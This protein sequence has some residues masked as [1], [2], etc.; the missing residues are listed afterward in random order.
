MLKHVAAA[1]VGPRSIERG[2]L[3]AFGV[4]PGGHLGSEYQ[5]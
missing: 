2:H 3:G 5:E 4:R 1:D